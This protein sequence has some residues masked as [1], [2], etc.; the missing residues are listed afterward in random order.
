MPLTLI[1]TCPLRAGPFFKDQAAKKKAATYHHDKWLPDT[2]EKE[3]GV[4]KH[5]ILSICCFGC[6]AL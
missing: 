4:S 1:G 2:I 5:Y 6:S 3:E